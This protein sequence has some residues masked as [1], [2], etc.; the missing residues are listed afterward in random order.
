VDRIPDTS[1]IVYSLT[2]R[3]RARTVSLANADTVRWEALR[4][5]VGHSYDLREERAGD[6]TGTLI[7]QPTDRLRLRADIAHSVHGQG[8][9]VA[10]SDLLVRLDPVSFSIGSR[11]SDPGDFNFITTGLVVDVTR[12]VTLRNTNFFDARTS[13]FVESRASAE[14]HFQCWALT[15]EYVHRER[16][17]DELLFAVNLLGVGG[18]VRTTVGLGALAGSGER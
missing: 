18:P 13:S 1:L 6:I 17:D 7:V 10:T 4:F 14:I 8:V 16:R 5:A 2:N 15:V 11:Y 3:V 12:Y 9:Q